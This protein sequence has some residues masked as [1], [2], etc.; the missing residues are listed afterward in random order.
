MPAALL[1][2]IAL[3]LQAE[4]SRPVRPGD[5]QLI[6]AV[7]TERP[8]GRILSQDFKESPRGGARIGCGLIE[9]EGHIEPY[10][11][12]AF[13]E[14]PSGTTVYLTSPDGARLPGQGDRTPEPAHWD[15]T[16]SAPGRA[17]NDGDGDIDRMDR[18]RDVMS[19]LHT[20][21][22]CRDLHP[23]AGVVWSMEIEPNPDPA[24][25]AEAEARAAMVTNL[26]F[27][28]A[29]TPGEPH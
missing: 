17:D 3:G 16:V 10:S 7:Q 2:L 9:I 4:A 24:K 26:I 12:M 18:N 19:R 22:L 8:A 25:A 14:T 28:P 29:S 13:W 21:T 6:A 23:P 15:I 27:G 1:A 20:R 5:D 11:V